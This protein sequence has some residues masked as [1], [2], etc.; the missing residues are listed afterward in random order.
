MMKMSFEDKSEKPQVNYNW[1]DVLDLRIQKPITSETKAR[2]ARRSFYYA[3]FSLDSDNE[4][5]SYARPV[6]V[7]KCTICGKNFRRNYQFKR[8]LKSHENKREFKCK[9]C[10]KAFNTKVSLNHHELIHQEKIFKCPECEK[11]FK[12]KHEVKRHSISHN[13]I[14]DF[15]CPKCGKLFRRNQNLQRHLLTHRNKELKSNAS[16][17]KFHRPWELASS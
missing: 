13:P 5:D 11:S 2:P 10:G 3:R 16:Q 1:N 15:E 9:V 7:F 17:G 12:I 8:H 4:T 14:K 6:R